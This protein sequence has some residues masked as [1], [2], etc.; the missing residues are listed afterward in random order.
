[1]LNKNQYINMCKKIKQVTKINDYCITCDNNR[2]N[3]DLLLSEL[4]FIWNKS[5]FLKKDCKKLY[6]FEEAIF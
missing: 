5:Y 4:F 2:F 6:F 1:M 3:F